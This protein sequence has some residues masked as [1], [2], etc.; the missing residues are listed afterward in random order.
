M[1]NN[2]IGQGKVIYENN[3]QTGEKE[4][5]NQL[6]NII[7]DAIPH[8]ILIYKNNPLLP[9]SRERVKIT[10]Q[11]NIEKEFEVGPCDSHPDLIQDLDNKHL[12]VNT[13]KATEAMSCII[14]AYKEKGMVE[15]SDDITTGGYYLL[16][17]N[18]NT[19]NSTQRM[20]AELNKNE[21]LQCIHFLNQ[22]ASN[23][24]KNKN[25]FPTV[26][27]WGIV[28]PFGFSIKFNSDGYFRWLQLYGMGQ[29][30]KTTLGNI[31]LSIWNL[32]KKGKS[33]GF[34]NIDSV[35]RFGHTVSKDTYPI[36][37]NEAGP[38]FT[39]SYGKYTPILE[40]LKHS[41]ESTTCR[42]KYYEG[43]SYQEVPWLS[44]P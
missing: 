23:G 19:V 28:S 32:N 8:K 5:K 11:S 44:A 36:L 38:L 22:L 14:N 9:N 40:L 27:K 13:K 16:K 7:I 15:Y 30:G 25:I 12:I 24:W 2:R 21:V 17:G 34:N 1:T 6:T 3:E 37:V 35:P 33:I 10:F 18:L 26:L 20:G 41:I 31:V 29:T 4:S 42:G 39:N 43:K